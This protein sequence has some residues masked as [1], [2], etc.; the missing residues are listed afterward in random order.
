MHAFGMK[1]RKLASLA[2][3]KGTLLA[4]TLFAAPAFAQSVSADGAKQLQASLTKTFGPALFDKGIVSI[5][6]QGS[7]YAVKLDLTPTFA[8]IKKS[9]VTVSM[10]PLTYLAT[11]NADGTY[12]VTSESAFNYSFAKTEGEDQSSVKFTAACKSSGTFDPKLSVFSSYETT[13]PSASATVSSP[14]SDATVS[15]GAITSKITGV[16]GNAG[17]VTISTA[18]TMSD[19]VETIVGK[20]KPLTIKITAKT[21]TSEST[22]ENFQ[23]GTALD[24]IGIAAKA[25]DKA[26][27]AAQQGDI[28]QKLT[29]ALPLWNNLSGKV[30]LNGVT[31]ETPIGP[32]AL[33]SIEENVGLT[34]A[35][36]QA[37]YGLGIK[38]N[39]LKLPDTPVIPAWAGPLVPAQGN[40]DLKF[41]GVDLDALARLAIQNF[42]VTKEP[43]IPDEVSAQALQIVMGG[44]PHVTLSPSTFS[45]PAGAL[46]A[47]GSMNVFPDKKGTVTISTADLD[48]LSDALGKAQVPNMP[49][50]VAFAKG[51]AKTAD[52][53]AVWAIDFDGDTK[54]VSVNGQVL[55][56]GSAPGGDD[57]DNGGN[58]A[59]G[60]DDNNNN[61]AQ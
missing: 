29:A 45:A 34:G 10:D 12:A 40:I 50:L 54:A 7:A 42:D 11:P 5:T 44:Q 23:I 56:P 18:G 3:L 2:A 16:A 9:G 57:G 37:S 6:P 14:Q 43:P 61:N 1:R 13:C 47:Q 55:N 35:V 17:G 31:V 30:T 19:F 21:A 39:G 48:K 36:K 27:I 46:S 24:I 58:G 25:G 51:L 20:D 60:G 26:D 59:G 41:E 53:K 4:A 22:A 28:K 38:Y 15:V 49:M 8:H 52:G 33:D 32:V